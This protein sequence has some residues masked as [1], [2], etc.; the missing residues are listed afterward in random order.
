MTNQYYVFLH[1]TPGKVYNYEAVLKTGNGQGEFTPVAWG[2]GAGPLAAL[3]HLDAAGV[4]GVDVNNI[5]FVREI[6]DGE[7]PTN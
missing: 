4:T 7:H 6:E 3:D 2:Y 5:T 1:P